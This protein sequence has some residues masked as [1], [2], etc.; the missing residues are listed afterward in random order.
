VVSC[1]LSCL[2]T[3]SVSPV[4][5]RPMLGL[6]AELSRDNKSPSRGCIDCSA[7][8]F[9]AYNFRIIRSRR[10]SGRYD[11]EGSY[12]MNISFTSPLYEHLSSL[13][14]SLYSPCASQLPNSEASHPCQISTSKDDSRINF[15]PSFYVP[16]IDI[17][18]HH[19]DTRS[20][21]APRNAL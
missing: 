20:G 13:N 9:P 11:P 15:I 2:C 7:E 1:L 18:T 16:T 12:K 17:S 4:A 14:H 21:G 10:K 3:V 5:Q 19:Q 6:I 8:H